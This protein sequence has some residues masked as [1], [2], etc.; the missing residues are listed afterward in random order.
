MIMAG[1]EDGSVVRIHIQQVYRRYSSMLPVTATAATAMPTIE[2][3][4]V[5]IGLQDRAAAAPASSA[6]TAAMSMWTTA[7]VP[8]GP[9]S[10]VSRNNKALRK[11]DLEFPMIFQVKS[12]SAHHL[13]NP[14]SA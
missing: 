4:T 12:L 7:A 9:L 2:A 3:T 14:V 8:T 13:K 10:V 11:R 6:S 1:A 5:T